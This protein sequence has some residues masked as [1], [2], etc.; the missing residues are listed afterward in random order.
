MPDDSTIHTNRNNFYQHES[1]CYQLIEMKNSTD[2]GIGDDDFTEWSSESKS[3]H[4]HSPHRKHDRKKSKTDILYDITADYYSE[5]KMQKTNRQQFFRYR[6]PTNDDDDNNVEI[7]E[8]ASLINLNSNYNYKS[9]SMIVT[10]STLVMFHRLLS[11]LVRTFS[12]SKSTNNHHFG[13]Q[14]SSDIVST[15]GRNN[16]NK[17]TSRHYGKLVSYSNPS[18]QSGTHHH[19][20]LPF[21]P[22]GGLKILL[23]RA[24]LPFV[25]FCFVFLFV[26][27]F[28]ANTHYSSTSSSSMMSSLS[29]NLDSI[30]T[31]LSL[32]YSN[33]NSLESSN[34]SSSLLLFSP[35][36]AEIIVYT[37]LTLDNVKTNEIVSPLMSSSPTKEL[38]QLAKN[39]TLKIVNIT[40]INNL[41]EIET[42]FTIPPCPLV[43]PKLGK[44]FIFS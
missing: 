21:K 9:T 39:E 11:S 14:P 3:G 40:V 32:N 34:S 41:T 13:Q 37:N 16:N 27:Q 20:H 10:S 28:R 31:S 30:T 25:V 4:S 35:T 2:D 29:L 1:I 44:L 6:L 36:A 5:Q 22:S 8:T 43:P 17:K 18:S 24:R 42:N 15:D 38:I 26:I 7:P 12:R 19:K 33:S 23:R